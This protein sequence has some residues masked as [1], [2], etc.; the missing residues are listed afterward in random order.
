MECT[1]YGGEGNWAS[2]SAGTVDGLHVGVLYI[3]D[4]VNCLPGSVA[5]DKQPWSLVNH[6]VA[7]LVPDY[8]TVT[9][10]LFL[11]HFKCS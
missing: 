2:C 10:F 7:T 1:P 6:L 8:M 4:W 9:L 3:S 11:F 5:A